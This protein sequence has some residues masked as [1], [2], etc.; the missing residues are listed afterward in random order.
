M[1]PK[2]YGTRRNYIGFLWHG[3]FL[4]ITLTFTDVNTV[5]PAMILRVGG[6]ELHIGIPLITKLLFIGFL[7]GQSRKKPYLLTGI[8]LRVVSLGLTA[9]T[10]ANLYRI[11]NRAV[12]ALIYMELLMF[13]VSRAFAGISYI[14]LIGSSSPSGSTPPLSP[15]MLPM[16]SSPIIS[17]KALRGTCSS[18]TSAVRSLQ[19]S[20]GPVY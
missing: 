8:Y 5:I 19:A 7:R 17:T 2:E 1:L 13:T 9:V 18:S 20:S 16:Q 3:V 11:D 6:R 15:S 12:M 10:L 4:S 14:D